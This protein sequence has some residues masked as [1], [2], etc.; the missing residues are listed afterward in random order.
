MMMLG[1]RPYTQQTVATK[2]RLIELL[3]SERPMPQAVRGYLAD[4]IARG[5]APSKFGP[6][7]FGYSKTQIEEKI[8]TGEIPEPIPL[9]ANARARGWT[10][11]QIIDWQNNLVALAPQRNAAAAAARATRRR[12]GAAS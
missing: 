2:P 9:S 5:V 7:V 12:S 10:G 6:Q 8:R 11:Q 4:L 1:L 3:R